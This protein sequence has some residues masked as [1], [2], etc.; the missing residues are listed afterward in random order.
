[1][2]QPMDQGAASALLFSSVFARLFWGMAVDAPIVHTAAWLCPIIG[3]LLF[4][5]AA[6][7]ARKFL[8]SGSETPWRQLGKRCPK[9]V[10]K[11][12]SILIAVLFLLDC[13]SGVRMLAGTA[14]LTSMDK[15]Q[16]FY[17]ILPLGAF[18][19]ISV[20]LG[21]AAAGNCAR[22]WNR[23]L[24]LLT[25]V[26]LVSHLRS[27]NPAWL[28]P[29]LGSGTKSILAGG[30]Y[31]TGAISLL[32]LMWLLA[33]PHGGKGKP[34]TAILIATLASSVQLAALQM[35]SPA[36]LGQQLNRSSRMLLVLSNGRTAMPLQI[37]LMLLCY[38]AFLQLIAAEATACAGFL[39]QALPKLPVWAFAV[40][41][42]V[43]SVTLASLPYRVI[44][45]YTLVFT[46][47]YPLL[48]VLI[49]ALLLASSIGGR[50]NSCAKQS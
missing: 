15:I 29:M 41:I 42:A 35:L 36:L 12:A 1:M 23:L 31:C 9:A 48:G 43:A 5:P 11:T 33:R 27:Y 2:K 3:F 40:G 20:L 10:F 4:L 8:P 39:S 28:T 19:A 47:Y 14:N 13:A 6:L 34:L 50:K 7:A 18:A 37:L 26:V 17:L 30:L 32:S 49:L 16:L 45:G 22:L 44:E 38:G 25:A 24:P 46:R 21:G